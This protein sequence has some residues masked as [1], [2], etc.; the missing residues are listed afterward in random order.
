MDFGKKAKEYYNLNS[1]SELM[2]GDLISCN[3]YGIKIYKEDKDGKYNLYFKKDIGEEVIKIHEIRK[4]ILLIFKKFTQIISSTFQYEFFYIFKYNIDNNE[5]ILLNQSTMSDRN[6]QYGTST[7][8]YLILNN[9]Y[10][11]ARYGLE[12]DVYDISQ[13]FEF[14]LPIKYN[15]FGDGKCIRR[16]KYPIS[17][18]LFTYEGY[19]FVAEDENHMPRFFAFKNNTF[20]QFKKFPFMKKDLKAIKRMDDNYFIIYN[21]NCIIIVTKY[22]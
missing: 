6:I 5:L 17:D 4:N 10:L 8:S 11:I 13:D 21:N 12:L 7:M 18:M 15:F 3:S 22:N 1:V 14:I 2:N 20:I 16:S 9:K 19:I